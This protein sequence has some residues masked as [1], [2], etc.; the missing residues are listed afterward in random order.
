M[1]CVTDPL[2]GHALFSVIRAR[3]A[4]PWPLNGNISQGNMTFTQ[5][6]LY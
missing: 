4:T 3:P 5:L 1:A 2:N 6:T